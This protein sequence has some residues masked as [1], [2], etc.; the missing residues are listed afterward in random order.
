MYWHFINMYVQM[1]KKCQKLAILIDASIET[2]IQS[3]RRHT[4]TIPFLKILSIL[5]SS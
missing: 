2:N 3:T 4:T 1:P 5:L